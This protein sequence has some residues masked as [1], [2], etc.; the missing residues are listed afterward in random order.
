MRELTFSYGSQWS[1]IDLLVH[2]DMFVLRD[3][4]F[5]FIRVDKDVVEKA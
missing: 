4:G 2:G 1:L 5:K 3:L